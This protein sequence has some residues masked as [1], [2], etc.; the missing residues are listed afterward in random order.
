MFN[1][2]ESAAITIS[3]NFP[4]PSCGSTR[5][6]WRMHVALPFVLPTHACL[7][8]HFDRDGY[9]FTGAFH[10]HFDRE[11]VIRKDVPGAVPFVRLVQRKQP[12]AASIRAPRTISYTANRYRL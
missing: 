9:R 11:I 10:S 12:G 1:L 8:D 3:P 7:T 5:F 4:P 6:R 2:E